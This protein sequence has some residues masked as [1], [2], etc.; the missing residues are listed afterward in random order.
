MS[1]VEP[2][3]IRLEPLQ[4]EG[5]S[6]ETDRHW[7]SL[8][9]DQLRPCLSCAVV[10]GGLGLANRWL[11]LI[12]DDDGHNGEHPNDTV[13]LRCRRQGWQPQDTV[14]MM[15]A[16]SVNSLRIRFAVID[17][18]SVLVAVTTG[19][20]NARRAGDPAEYRQLQA[21]PAEVGTI[22][23][24]IVTSATMTTGVMVEALMIATEAKAA[25]LQDFNIISTASP[26]I[27][28]GT[29]TDA[30]AIFSGRGR[31]VA[32]AGK[33]TVFGERLAQ[34]TMTA[35]GDSIGRKG[36][37]VEPLEDNR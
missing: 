22:N 18:E 26:G 20:A 21:V 6:L 16:A 3:C 15:T 23:M 13:A 25:V 32:F 2:I 19:L 28:T 12:V 33:H 9:F 30:Q 24:A 5:V 14:A 27:A 17:N 4:V 35:L 10:N 11:N 31:Q 8:A 7:I 34:L 29:G 1:A 36:N 37:R